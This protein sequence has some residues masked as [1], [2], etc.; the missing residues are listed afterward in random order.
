M[1]AIISLKNITK[2][3]GGHEILKNISFSVEKGDVFGFIG[4]NGAGKTTTLKTILGIIEPTSGEVKI[5]GENPQNISVKKRIGFMPENTYL[6]KYLTGDEFL[7]YAAGFYEISK[8]K[9]TERK[10]WV[11]KK[12]GLEGARARR[13]STYSKGMLQR[14]GIAQAILHD[15]ELIF[16]DEPMSGLDPIG[17]KMIKD[18]LLELKQSGKAIF[19]NSHILPDVEAVCDKYAIIVSG[20]ILKQ[21]A[22]KELSESLETVFMQTIA[23]EKIDVQ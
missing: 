4:P 12:V 18:L 16:L 5:F 14:I 7:D 17:R 20:K 2:N 22:M 19:L 15:P 23:G 10:N 13:L 1:S 21:G 6:Y 9:I 11:L 8:E 3:I